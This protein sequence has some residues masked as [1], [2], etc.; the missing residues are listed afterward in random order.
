MKEILI[1][2]VFHFQTA[3]NRDRFHTESDMLSPRRQKEL[4]EVL[5][6]LERFW[7]TKIAVERSP[8]TGGA[9]GAEY[10]AYVR[11]QGELAVDE[12]QQIGFRLGKRLGHSQLYCVDWNEAVP[13]VGSVFQ[14]MADHPSARI[15]RMNQEAEKRSADDQ[16]YFDRSTVGE[17]L[18]ML[19]SQDWIE[20]NHR[21][22][23]DYALLGDEEDSTGAQW[24]AQYWYYRNL[25]IWKNVMGLFQNPEEKVLLLIG[26]GHLHYLRQLFQEHGE[27]RLIDGAEVLRRTQSLC[28]S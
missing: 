28:H 23:L 21:S 27:V 4:E 16:A 22:Y 15:D 9:L 20:T 25:R 3:G 10:Q 2:G 17:Y 7:P 8:Q 12:I 18:A 6:A 13:N 19:N 14:W 24:V 26:A 5:A 11:G 1:L